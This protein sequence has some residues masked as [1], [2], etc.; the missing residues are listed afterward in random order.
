MSKTARRSAKHPSI[1]LWLAAHEAAHVVA[2]I[3]LSAAYHLSDVNR[4]GCIEEVRVWIEPDGTL[5]GLCTWDY[6]QRAVPWPY[7]AISWAAGP[8]AEARVREVD[9]KECLV[10]S[11]DYLM[12]N[13]YAER[14]YADLD[15]A[16]R[17]G[18]RIVEECWDDIL[19]LAAFLQ[20]NGSADFSQVSKVLDLP[21]GRC[22]YDE[23]TRPDPS[24][25]RPAVAA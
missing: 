1:P 18:T 15:E 14:G 22:I 13:H 23:D 7:Q 4:P 6:K 8:I 21:N 3:Q 5:R 9:P 19:K 24:P 20:Q 11:D 16:I 17:E 12:L 10:E 25:R 2:R